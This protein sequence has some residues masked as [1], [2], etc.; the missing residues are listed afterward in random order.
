MTAH[1]RPY[2]PSW[3]L[4][5]LTFR[6]IAATI[7]GGEKVC[8]VRLQIRT[9]PLTRYRQLE[10]RKGEI[11]DLTEAALWYRANRPTITRR[12]RDGTGQIT[13]MSS[14]LKFRLEERDRLQDAVE[15]SG[16][17]FMSPED[18]ATLE[19]I[20]KS[21][22]QIWETILGLY[23]EEIRNHSR[24][25][26]Q[27]DNFTP[28]NN[29]DIAIL[30]RLAAKRG[31]AL[32][33]M[34]WTAAMMFSMCRP[35]VVSNLQNDDAIQ[36]LE[37]NLE[38]FRVAKEDSDAVG[39]ANIEALREERRARDEE[40]KQ[41][42]KNMEGLARELGAMKE[43]YETDIRQ[44][45]DKVFGLEK[46]VNQAR[47]DSE[48]LE[49]AP[50][51]MVD[52]MEIKNKEIEGLKDREA[53]LLN[54]LNRSKESEM[55]LENE[56]TRLEE[57]RETSPAWND[58]S[59]NQMAENE[60]EIK[61]LVSRSI[62]STKLFVKLLKNSVTGDASEVF[63]FSDMEP[64]PVSFI[65]FRY[66]HRP[67]LHFDVQIGENSAEFMDPF[68]CDISDQNSWS[69]PAELPYL[70]LVGLY[71]EE[72]SSLSEEQIRQ[73]LN[74]AYR[75]SV[76][77]FAPPSVSSARHIDVLAKYET[78]VLDQIKLSCLI[79]F[80]LKMLEVNKGYG[81]AYSEAA[82]LLTR[83]HATFD[84]FTDELLTTLDRDPENWD[85]LKAAGILR[86]TMLAREC[87]SPVPGA[88]HIDIPDFEDMRFKDSI[89]QMSGLCIKDMPTFLAETCR[90]EITG[91]TMM[92]PW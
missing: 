53:D 60:Q 26:Q 57:E 16:L 72:L 31:E 55:R 25:T 4:N 59:Q 32:L 76:M 20:N 28:T 7:E 44:R 86:L 70:L 8:T 14:A 90:Q 17:D 75:C 40:K 46:Q 56:I 30:Q 81:R 41:H 89:V 87:V 51:D 22:D 52:N 29:E 45:D 43:S 67:P 79:H 61:R 68:N 12:L 39:K 78:S 69:F 6:Q 64:L 73:Q 58:T 34:N 27:L 83:L 38:K 63:Q 9:I 21:K 42:K 23:G 49:L 18:R 71:P 82:C 33:P 19:H 92:D 13:L 35:E 66:N 80:L 65:Q 85:F 2:G 91:K 77:R 88:T 54:Q 62:K 10:Q 84:I 47:D 5:D 36:D 3:S 74:W 1:H 37:N 50:E 15:A 24:G 11:V 48:M